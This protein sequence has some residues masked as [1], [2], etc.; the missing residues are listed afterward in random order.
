MHIH[1][2]EEGKHIHLGDHD[3]NDTSGFSGGKDQAREKQVE[4]TARLDALQEK[5]YAEH[6]HK[7]LIVLQGMDT[8]GKD[9]TVRAVFDGI[10]PQGVRITSFKVP[11]AEEM[12][13]DYLWRVHQEVPRKGEI[14]V[15]NRS[16]YED[17][18]VVRVHEIVTKQEWKRRYAQI[19]NLEQMLS[20]E[21][22]TILKFFLHIDKDE[23]KQR[24]LDRLNDPAKHWKFNPG[25][26][27]E[28]ELW[29]AYTQAYEDVLGKTSFSH[30]PWYIV[31]ANKKWYRNLFIATALVETLENLAIQ[32]PPT[33]PD[34]DQYITQLN[35]EKD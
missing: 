20:E 33:L 25:D 10:N 11:T 4:L 24:L 1:P 12:D 22:T 27:K 9:G 19:N 16:H 35:S 17:V 2:V 26:L 13:H 15:F 3:A 32:T 29:Q 14:V 5:L 23:Q 34:A 7:I 21:G 6:R 31:P 30:A 28:R 8:S 18:L